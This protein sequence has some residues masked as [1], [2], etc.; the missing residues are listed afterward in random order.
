MTR[1]QKQFFIGAASVLFF[2]GLSVYVFV[3]LSPE[4]IIN[5]VG[6][7]NAY[8]LLFVTAVLGGFTIFNVIPY[9]LLLVTFASGGLNPLFLG[10]LAATGV[11][12]GDSTSFF[13]G[14][15]GS[16]IMPEKVGRWFGM[17]YRVAQARPKLFMLLC[18][19]YS[20]LLP[21]SNDFITIP[22]GLA[23]LPFWKTMT[24]LFLGN[25]IFNVTLAFLAAH[26]FDFGQ[27]A[28]LAGF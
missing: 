10:V 25:I 11:M 22:A 17:L 20:S 5:W 7:N 21:M 26:A 1:K 9:H 8:A 24:P 12:L 23:R 15:Q 19:V 14:Y 16:A 4:K 2:V 18:F 27:L 3:Y 13:V 6:V 28:K